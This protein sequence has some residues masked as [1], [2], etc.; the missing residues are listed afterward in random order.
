LSAVDVAWSFNNA[1]RDGSVFYRVGSLQPYM[2][3]WEVVDVDTVRLNWKEGQFLPW[4]VT[5]LS[6]TASADPWMTS[7]GLVDT[8]GETK[9]SQVPVATGPYEVESWRVGERM[10]LKAVQGHWRITPEVETFSVIEL[11]EPLT[12]VAAFKTGELDFA[13]IPN[14]LLQSTLDDTAGAT[15]QV[16]GESQMGCVNFTGNYWQQKDNNPASP[17]FGETIFPRPGFDASHPWVGDPTDG[18]SMEQARLVRRALVLAI[19]HDAINDELFGGFGA[20]QGTAV[21]GWG[22]GIG[23]WVD[24]FERNYDPDESKRLLAE[25]GY[26]D[27]FEIPFY[28]PADHPRVNPEAGE[29]IAQMWSDIGVDVDLEISAYAAR[30]PKRFDGVDDPPWYHCGTI[31]PSRVDRP[32]DGGMGPTSTFRGFEV[33][34]KMVPLYFA[35]FTEPSRDKRIQ[36]NFEIVEYVLDWELQTAFIA[37]QPHYAV[38]PKIG[39]WSPHAIDAPIFTNAASVTL[40]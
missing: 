22:P 6:Q 30:R 28:V 34:D 33:E 18:A 5:N 1:M 24:K 32:F 23:G 40:K 25:A 39:S 2:N 14:S 37:D 8:L 16:V 38:G 13:P 27:G 3:Q 10:D 19:D 12:M 36:N 29:A 9:A 11:R 21:T 31:S 26:A 35:N 7:F 17:N 20:T 4:W 15:K